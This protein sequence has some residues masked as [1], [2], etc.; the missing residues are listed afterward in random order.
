MHRQET[1]HDPQSKDSKKE[2]NSETKTL[3]EAQFIKLHSIFINII[4]VIILI[5]KK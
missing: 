1:A 2:R 4:T 5:I 3:E